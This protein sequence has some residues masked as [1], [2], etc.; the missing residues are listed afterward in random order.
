MA[1]AEEVVIGDLIALAWVG[2]CEATDLLKVT[3]IG[4]TAE[5]SIKFFGYRMMGD[6]TTI[7]LDP[8]APHDELIF[9]PVKEY[10]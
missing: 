5:G 1:Y 10:V 7:S 6:G 3:T 2:E 8:M 9:W 4:W